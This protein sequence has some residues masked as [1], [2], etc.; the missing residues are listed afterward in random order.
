MTI[1]F[2]IK[3]QNSQ[4]QNEKKCKTYLLRQLLHDLVEKRSEQTNSGA[5]FAAWCE[6]FSIITYKHLTILKVH[7][8]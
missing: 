4:Q 1:I 6:T 8:A 5:D 3:R 2:D 7:S